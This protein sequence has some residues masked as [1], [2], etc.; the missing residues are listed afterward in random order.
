MWLAVMLLIPWLLVMRVLGNADPGWRMPMG[1]L[2]LTAAVGGHWLI[3]RACGLAES[4]RFGWITLL[5]LSAVPW[6][7]VVET[8]IVR[9]MTQAVVLAVAELYQIFGKP[10]E[11]IGD[12]LRLHDITVEVTD[13]CS[14]V[15]SFQSFIMATWFFTELMHLQISRALILL[16]CGC[17]A[18]FLVNMARTY[19]LA[20]IRFFHGEEAFHKAHDG[21]GIAAFVVSAIFFYVL[22]G[23]LAES[24]RTVVRTVKTA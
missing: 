15:R 10:V 23:K 3:A 16:G 19:G 18:A 8:R 6:P 22:S 20:H 21:M 2:G 1:L 13:G 5:L 7:S 17:G 12:R 4:A 14:G 11:V 9:E 24:K